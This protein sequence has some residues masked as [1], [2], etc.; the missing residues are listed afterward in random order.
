MLLLAQEG[1]RGTLTT[2]CNPSSAF[3]SLDAT[4]IFWK[5]NYFHVASAAPTSANSC[6]F[7]RRSHLAGLR[8]RRKPRCLGALTAYP[9]DSHCCGRS[10]SRRLCRLA[11]LEYLFSF[12]NTA[13]LTCN[14]GGP[15]PP[16]RNNIPRQEPVRKEQEICGEVVGVWLISAELGQPPN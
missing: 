12:P 4:S 10:T 11:F 13:Q 9:I 1:G 6:I 15:A 2:N 5:E 8:E 16:D 3:L 7:Q 14:S